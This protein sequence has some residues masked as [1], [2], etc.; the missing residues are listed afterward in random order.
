MLQSCGACAASVAP[1][2]RRCPACRT[3]RPRVI[4]HEPRTG[5][6]RTLRLP[7]RA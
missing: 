6:A 1:E 2:L 3:R 5:R 7:R 4:G